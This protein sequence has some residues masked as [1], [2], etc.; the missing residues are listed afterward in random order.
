MP[1]ISLSKKLKLFSFLSGF[2]LP[3]ILVAYIE[4]TKYYLYFPILILIAIFNVLLILGIK[5]FLKQKYSLWLGILGVVV[6]IA[7]FFV[8]ELILF[9]MRQNSQPSY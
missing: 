1:K 6:P 3:T 5:F 2:I 4:L 8:F 9:I 7:F